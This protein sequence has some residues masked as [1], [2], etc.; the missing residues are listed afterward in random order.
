MRTI[1]VRRTHTAGVEITVG[2]ERQTL[3]GLP[4]Y[5]GPGRYNTDAAM[6]GWR[7]AIGPRLRARLHT[8]LCNYGR[9]EAGPNYSH[10]TRGHG[11]KIA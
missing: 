7:K 3:A 1:T 6:I 8:A 2:D 5:G 9:R 10:N 4:R 11:W